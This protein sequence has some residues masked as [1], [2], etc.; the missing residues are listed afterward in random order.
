MF[1]THLKNLVKEHERKTRL[2][3]VKDEVHAV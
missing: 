1:S 2:S 3:K